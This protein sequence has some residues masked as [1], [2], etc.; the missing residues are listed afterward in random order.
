[1]PSPWGEAKPCRLD[2]KSNEP[3]HGKTSRIQRQEQ[4]HSQAG[5]SE[6]L[7]WAGATAST[8]TSSRGPRARVSPEHSKGNPTQ[9]PNSER[10]NEQG[11]MGANNHYVNNERKGTKEEREERDN[12]REKRTQRRQERGERG[13]RQPALPTL[14]RPRNPSQ[15]FA[16]G[17]RAREYG[18]GQ[19]ETRG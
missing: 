9:P 15:E 18:S 19:R 10:R 16:D 12:G 3:I 7:K 4:L 11:G 6:T 2:P 14:T 13:G 8:F 1:M 5:N 17:R